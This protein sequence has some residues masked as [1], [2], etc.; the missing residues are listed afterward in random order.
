MTATVLESARTFDQDRPS[1]LL[2]IAAT[3]ERFDPR[4]FRDDL[5]LSGGAGSEAT[6]EVE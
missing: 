6:T 2:R 1:R 5:R 4:P 3:D